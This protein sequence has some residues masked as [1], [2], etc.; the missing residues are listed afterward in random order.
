MLKIH[1][2]Q[3]DR[4]E[5]NK[6]GYNQSYKTLAVSQMRYDIGL[7]EDGGSGDDKWS[8]SWLYFLNSVFRIFQWTKFFG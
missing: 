3:G 8:N 4:A 1:K 6:I 2:L 5:I 7:D